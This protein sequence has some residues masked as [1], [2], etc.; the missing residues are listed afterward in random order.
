MGS[1]S[2]PRSG[3]YG[4]QGPVCLLAWSKDLKN[5]AKPTLAREP[6]RRGVAGGGAQLEGI[7]FIV[8]F[9]CSFCKYLSGA[10]YMPFTGYTE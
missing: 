6:G 10:Q 5:K 1:I 3:S 7:L 2:D 4:I 9:I 8:E